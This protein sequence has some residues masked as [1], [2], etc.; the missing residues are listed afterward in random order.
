MY[1]K[2]YPFRYSH[3][4]LYPTLQQS[5]FMETVKIQD[6]I[7][8]NFNQSKSILSEHFFSSVGFLL[9]DYFNCT[10]EE[11]LENK[12][13]PSFC[14]QLQLLDQ[15]IYDDH[16]LDY[17]SFMKK[18]DDASKSYSNK[19]IGDYFS[20]RTIETV[21]LSHKRIDSF[22]IEQRIK[23]LSYLIRQIDALLE[24]KQFFSVPSNYRSSFLQPEKM[25]D[26]LDIYFFMFPFLQWVS[27]WILFLELNFNQNEDVKQLVLQLKN[28]ISNTQDIYDIFKKK[29]VPN[30]IEYITNV[31]R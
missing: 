2:I 29:S 4:D 12:L 10:L 14:H 17:V 16:E 24:S 18:Y 23:H 31:N 5:T 19:N 21:F 15:Y 1:L 28:D 11:W 22:F 8:S 13:K 7:R 3:G 6:E 20:L 26:Y 25:D 30:F 9:D 27:H